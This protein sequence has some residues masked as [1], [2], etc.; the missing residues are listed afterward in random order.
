M[1]LLITQL[2]VISRAIEQLNNYDYQGSILRV[3]I[4]TLIY[5]NSSMLYMSKVVEY[6]LITVS[7]LFSTLSWL[8]ALSLVQ[9]RG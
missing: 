3:C 7:S 9:Y 6:I 5:C 4:V 8:Y 1:M 2:F